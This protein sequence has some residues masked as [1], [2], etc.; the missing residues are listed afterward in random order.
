MK[1]KFTIAIVCA[2]VIGMI[3]F[4]L[5][6]NKKKI[7]EKKQPAK[8]ENILIPVT[9]DTAREE[10]EQAGIVKTGMLAPFRE[11]KILSV[12]SGNIRRLLFNLGDH[13]RQGQI[14]AVIDTRLLELDL[15]KS[16]ANVSK[17]QRDL[18]T[19]TELLAGNAATQEKVN[20]IRQNYVDAVSQYEH[21]KRQIA[22]AG[23]KAPTSGIIGTKAV[24][25]GMFITAGGDI[26]TIVNISRL[27]VRVN[28]TESEVYQVAQGQ[29]IKL[30]T[31]VYP[32]RSFPGTVTFISP[33]ASESHNYQV[34]IAADNDKDAPLRPGT[35]V[36]ADFSEKNPQKILLIPR[37]ALNE[38]KQDAT[39]YVIKEGRAVLRK[40][41][42]GGEY[43]SNI[44]V[45]GGLQP[46]EQVV[47]S[48]QINLK[49]GTLVNVSK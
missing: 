16:A 33:Q 41:K 10:M 23:I 26:A 14:L 27:K 8:T 18:Q 9:I 25:E 38:S 36:Y 30:T 20:G 4:R 45:T 34:E 5:V 49:E 29:K 11:A 3:L 1:K 22:D 35:F 37:S 24:E 13:V 44:Q 17:L 47:T 32:D 6:T 39:V 2:A 40:I 31:D 15:Q 12:S 48:G 46:G 28:L 43:G 7:N 21:V 42:A 19:Y